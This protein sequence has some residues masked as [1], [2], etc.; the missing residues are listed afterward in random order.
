LERI[1]EEAPPHIVGLSEVIMRALSKQFRFIYSQDSYGSVDKHDLF[2]YVEHEALGVKNGDGVSYNDYIKAL[3]L[4]DDHSLV[5]T[6]R[7]KRG[8]IIESVTLR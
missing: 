8:T 2:N 5:R 3:N 7:N 1:S 4:L 6:A